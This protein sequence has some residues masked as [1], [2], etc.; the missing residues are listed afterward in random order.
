MATLTELSNGMADAVERI[1]PALVTVDARRRQPASGVVIGNELVITADHVI[2]REE[3]IHVITHD[4]RKVAATFAGRDPATDLALLRVPGLNLDAA[5]QAE[6]VKVGQFL[7]AV[8]RPSAEGVM[9]SWGIVSAVG[10]PLRTRRGGMVEQFIRTDAI[11]YPGFSGGALIS[12]EG[13]VLGILTTGLAGGVAIGI[14]A[15]HA[16]RIADTLAQ[17][18]H[19][20]K[21][22]LGV[23]SQ[24]V[25][26]PEAQRGGLSQTDGLLIMR[27][28]PDSPAEKGGVLLGDILVSLDGTN[29]SDAGELQA[30]LT[31]ARVGTAVPVVVIRGGTATTLNVT[32]GVRK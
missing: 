24:P 31:G 28:E 7:L 12:A 13:T 15:T 18:G 8:G 26:L 20:K 22:Y 11:P 21:G 14:P 2:E 5:Q 4:G 17:H 25:R 30:L 9:A 27:V 29:I 23:T 1:S 6:S 3:D 19:V 16:W 10:G 32:I